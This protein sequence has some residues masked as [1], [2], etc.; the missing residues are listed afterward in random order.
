M[1]R[2]VFAAIFV[3]LFLVLSIPLML[4]ELLV[5]K[6][7]PYAADISQL[8]VVQW[9]FRVVAFISGVKTTFKGFENIPKDQPVLFVANHQSMF[10]IIIVYGH[11]P[12]L[13]GFVAKDSLKKVPLLSTYMK[14]LYCVF[15]NR[16]DLRAG[17]QMIL[18]AC[19]HIRSGVSILIFPEGT[20]NRSG[21]ETALGPFHDGSFKIAQKTGCP[22]IPISVNNTSKVFEDHFPSIKK[23]PVVVE[24]G[25]PVS[26]ADLT[27]E[28]RKNIGEHFRGVIAEMVRKNAIP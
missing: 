12:Y 9:A 28:E 3:F 8:R 15:L 14:R 23:A 11:L 16:N 6:I 26:F 27:P 17:L 2:T 20:R 5:K 10:D 1:I 13:T 25:E 18:T 7:N 4:I 22:I 21:D 24:F 19:D